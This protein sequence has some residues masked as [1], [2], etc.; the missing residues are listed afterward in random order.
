MFHATSVR[1]ILPYTDY[2]ESE[3]SRNMRKKWLLFLL[4]LGVF[5]LDSPVH[6]AVSVSVGVNTADFHFLGDYGNWVTVPKYGSV[7]R[8]SVVASWR[9]FDHGDWVWTDQ[10]W[11]WTSY[12]PYGWAVYHY[13]NWHYE[14]PVGWVWI[15]GYEWSPARVNWISFGDH[16]GWAPLAPKGAV[17]PDPWVAGRVRYWNV[18]A[19]RDFT[20]ENVF[21]FRIATGVRP[22]ASIQIVRVAPR[23]VDVERVVNRK[24]AVVKINTV[25]V[26]GGPHVF[27][28]V[29]YSPAVNARIA[30]HRTHV[31][32]Q[33]IK[34]KTTTTVHKKKVQTKKTKVKKKPH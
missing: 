11:M 15:P 25:E 33:V 8:P 27:R 24:I 14:P 23:I 20:R 10:G 19:V 3:V 16:I 13:G 30:V 6:A 18:V 7:W 4:V 26:R 17:L 29:E 5:A 21:K 2:N 1:K 34:K 28:R 32:K 9:P 22:R 31:E 12:E